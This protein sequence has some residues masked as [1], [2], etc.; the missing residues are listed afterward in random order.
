MARMLSSADVVA[1]LS[2]PEAVEILADQLSRSAGA[3]DTDHECLRD[4]GQR[5][6]SNDRKPSQGVPNLAGVHIDDGLR[7]QP[8]A[9][10]VLREPSSGL[11]GAPDYQRPSR[12]AQLARKIECLGSKEVFQ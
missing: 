3:Y 1:T 2:E 8:V 7:H 9:H 5:A 12:M 11:S 6:G 10:E 4:C